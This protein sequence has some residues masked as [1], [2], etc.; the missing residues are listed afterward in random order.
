LWKQQSSITVYRLATKENKLLFS[1]SRKQTAVC[2]FCFPHIYN[3]SIDI[4]FY[5][6]MAAVSNGKRVYHLLIVQTKVIRLQT[7]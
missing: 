3:G 7:D 5:I 2:R 1:V 6:N 4:Y